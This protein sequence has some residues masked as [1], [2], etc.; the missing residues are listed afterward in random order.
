MNI[1]THD[2]KTIVEG[3]ILREALKNVGY[4][5]DPESAR[6]AFVE[7]QDIRKERNDRLYG[8]FNELFGKSEPVKPRRP[9]EHY[10]YQGFTYDLYSSLD[11]RKGDIWYCKD[12]WWM[13]LNNTIS[14]KE[15]MKRHT[16][17]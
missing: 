5:I 8:S 7:Y 15:Y 3:A 13:V 4:E 9:I 2:N 12:H 1:T 14:W 17:S 6:K 11:A 16:T 10:E